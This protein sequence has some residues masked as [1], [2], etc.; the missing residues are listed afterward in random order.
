MMTKLQLEKAKVLLFQQL[1]SLLNSKNRRII[2]AAIQ[3][4]VKCFVPSEYGVNNS[5]SAARQINAVFAAKGDVID[6]PKTSQ[7]DGKKQTEVT[8]Q[9]W[10]QGI[11][12]QYCHFFKQTF[13][14]LN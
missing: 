12:M 14:R 4:R 1:A 8:Q 10:A 13:F 2:D 7:V 11:Q 3:A 6:Y 9:N 5:L